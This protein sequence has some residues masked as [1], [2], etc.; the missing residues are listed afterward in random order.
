MVRRGVVG[1]ATL[2]VEVFCDAILESGIMICIISSAIVVDS[3]TSG[4][5]W[6]T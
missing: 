1:V 3:G 5:N 2:W 4:V 6:A